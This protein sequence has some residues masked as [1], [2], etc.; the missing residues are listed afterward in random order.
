MT[1][2]EFLGIWLVLTLAIGY[3]GLVGCGVSC[4]LGS[5]GGL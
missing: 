5:S 1:A 3:V 4:C 2:Q